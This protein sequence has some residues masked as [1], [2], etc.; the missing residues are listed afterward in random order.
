MRHEIKLPPMGEEDEKEADVAVW[1]VAR[2]DR[3]EEGTD[4]L[5]LTTDKAAFTVPSPVSGVVTELVVSEGDEVDVGEI[6]CVVES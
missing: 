4:L 3:V 1:L 5:E 2:G 6:L